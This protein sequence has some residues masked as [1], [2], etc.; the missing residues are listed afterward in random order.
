MPGDPGHRLPR[1]L[2]V[3]AA[4][5][6]A[7]F[8]VAVGAFTRQYCSLIG[9]DL[10]TVFRLRDLPLREV[11]LLPLGGQ[12]V[13]LHRVLAWAVDALAPMSF[14]AAWLALLSLHLLGAVALHATLQRLCRTPQNTVLIALYAMHPLLGLHLSWFSSGLTRL[15]YIAL[16]AVALHAYL[17]H[18]AAPRA[19]H[20][21]TLAL[22]FLLA[23]GF[24]TK[25]VLVPLY[26]LGLEVA[27]EGGLVAR[28]RRDAATRRRVLAVLG[29]GAIAGAHVLVAR[30]AL[31]GLA[32]ETHTDLGFHVEF[33]KLAWTVLSSSLAGS[34]VEFSTYA[35]AWPGPLLLALVVA[36]TIAVD[37]S[38]ARIWACLAALVSVN[39]AVIAVS[40]RTVIYGA[41]MA[42][43]HRHHFEVVFLC[44]IFAGMVAHRLRGPAHQ[45]LARS[46]SAGLVVLVAA[47]CAFVGLGLRS[48]GEFTDMMRRSYGDMPRARAFL[49]AFERDLAAVAARPGAVVEEGDFPP[50]LS[51]MDY[52]YRR[53]SSLA[54]AFHAPVRFG[55]PAEAT[56][57]VDAA[58][59][60]LVPI[61][62]AR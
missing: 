40:S 58:T 59:G 19:R 42:F 35:R 23:L 57:R 41:L 38:V 45:A 21:V 10:S 36:G 49:D 28:L 8:T 6:A 22:A 31:H 61:P 33:Q 24:Y 17:G 2:P 14:P 27:C 44:V 32:A 30:S 37:R 20:L 16:S 3:V 50:F 11:V 47:A 62:G 1:A 29:M 25:A 43:E 39:F 34:V 15:P 5:S 12:L 46:R 60:H 53:Y 55:A 26:C 18:R 13:P 52:E 4:L 9:D 7:A 56:H 51:T 54:R 48:F